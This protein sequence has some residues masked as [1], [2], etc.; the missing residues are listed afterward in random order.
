MNIKGFLALL[1]EYEISHPSEKSV[2][3]SLP[4]LS[5]TSGK[6]YFLVAKHVGTHTRIN[7]REN[8]EC[9]ACVCVPQEAITA[10]FFNVFAG[11]SSRFYVY[12]KCYYV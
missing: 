6:Q 11:I 7:R 12:S 3:A 1:E 4:R 2:R 9:R 10:E 5:L 8:S